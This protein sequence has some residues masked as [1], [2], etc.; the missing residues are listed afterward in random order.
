FDLSERPDDLL[1]NN[2]ATTEENCGQQPGQAH[3]RASRIEIRTLGGWTV[4]LRAVAVI[5]GHFQDERQFFSHL[6]DVP[7][8]PFRLTEGGFGL[9]NTANITVTTATPKPD[10]LPGTPM[11]LILRRQINS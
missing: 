10:A 9:I 1:D 5:R 6:P 2:F 3:Q 11:P 4:G 8:I 7:T